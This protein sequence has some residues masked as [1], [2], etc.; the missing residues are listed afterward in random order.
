MTDPW[1]R[2]SEFWTMIAA[3]VQG[4]LVAAVPVVGPY[5]Q[6]G[7]AVLSAA[8]PLL[9]IHGRSQVKKA[10]VTPAPIH[11]VIATTVEAQ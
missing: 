9:Y 2:R 6:I 10:L 7:S 8:A 11:P 4:P 5:V 3:F 1:Y